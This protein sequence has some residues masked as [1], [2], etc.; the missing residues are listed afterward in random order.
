M[1]AQ[2]QVQDSGK[3]KSRILA[4]LDE[5]RVM[6]VA[7]LRPDGWP[8]ATMVGY[9]HDDLTLY[10]AVAR[11][12]QKLANI[13]REPRV[14]IAIGRQSAGDRVRGLSMAARANEVTDVAEVVR[15]DALIAERYPGRIV[16][17][18][19][20]KAA[21]VIR[22]TPQLVS[23]IDQDEGAPTLAQVATETVVRPI[24]SPAT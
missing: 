5:N 16:F 6:T 22:V 14:S 1:A 8:Q 7:T 17:A 20:G 9:V 3:L 10:F 2:P 24:A 19:Q 4:I 15:L 21:A 13:T 18:P 12:S 11:D 23:V